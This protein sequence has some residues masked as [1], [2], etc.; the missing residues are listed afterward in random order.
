MSCMCVVVILSF[1][2]PISLEM[3]PA[4]LFLLLTGGLQYPVRI[5]LEADR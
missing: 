1:S 2:D 5:R 4:F 3:Y